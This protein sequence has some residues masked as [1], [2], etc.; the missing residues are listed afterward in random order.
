MN[1]IS[2]FAT[3]FLLIILLPLIFKD[4]FSKE[5]EVRRKQL[6]DLALRNK[7]ELDGFCLQWLVDNCSQAYVTCGEFDEICFVC[8]Q[9]ILKNKYDIYDFR[10]LSGYGL[11]PFQLTTFFTEFLKIPTINNH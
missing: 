2:F 3:P 8:K 1:L 7:Y 11:T 9:I 10:I 6:Q 5:I 4:D